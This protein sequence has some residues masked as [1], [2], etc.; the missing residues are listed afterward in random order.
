MLPDPR[1]NGNIM[2]AYIQERELVSNLAKEILSELNAS[3][4]NTSVR[5]WPTTRKSAETVGRVKEP[6]WKIPTRACLFSSL[7]WIP[8]STFILM[9]ITKPQQCPSPKQRQMGKGEEEG[10]RREKA[11][12]TISAYK[13]GD[14]VGV[15]GGGTQGQ[16]LTKPRNI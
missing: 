14:E 12:H 1:T 16:K 2:Q 3:H 7:S 13:H 5:Y 11:S 15:V 10:K 8:A 4:Q 9:E 6:T